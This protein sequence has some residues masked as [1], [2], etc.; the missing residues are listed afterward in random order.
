[1]TITSRTNE[2]F[3]NY[4]AKKEAYRAKL[5]ELGFRQVQV[6]VLMR[7]H[8]DETFE[9]FKSQYLEAR[10]FEKVNDYE[11]DNND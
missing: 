8:H 2:V 1:M 3:E 5:I 11:D 6:E 10:L 7:L 9:A 4:V